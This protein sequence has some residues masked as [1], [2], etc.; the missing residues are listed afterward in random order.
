MGLHAAIKVRRE[1]EIDGDQAPALIDTTVGRLIFNDP[2]PQDLG[3]VDRSDPEKL[4]D[5]EID[6]LVT[7][8]QLGQIIDRCIQVHGTATTA[9]VLDEIKAQGFKYSTK[10]A[11]TVAVCDA[12]IPPQKKQ[13]LDEA[14]QKID[15]VVAQ[16]NRGLHLRRRALQPG[17]R[18]LGRVHHQ[19]LRR[20]DGQP[21]PVQPHLHDG[22]LRRPRL[23]QPDPPAGRHAR[24]D[25]QHLRARPSRCPSAPTTARA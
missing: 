16:Y 21:R 10:G 20:P 8:K 4:L 13:Y 18:D 17:G 23:H 2:I 3:Y 12:V 24:P 1:K 11:I 9:E 7:K 25:R 19:G 22:R 14:D 15:Q 6:F 5:L